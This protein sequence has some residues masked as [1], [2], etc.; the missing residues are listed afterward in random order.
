MLRIIPNKIHITRPFRLP[1]IRPIYIDN[2]CVL[3]LLPEIG[4]KWLDC[5]RYSNNGA[6]IGAILKQGRCG[7][8]L[9]FDGVNDYIDCGNDVSLNPT[10][11]VTVETWIKLDAASEGKTS[12]IPI[13][14]RN[15]AY[16]LRRDGVVNGGYFSFFIYD[17]TSWELGV[18][19]GFS[20]AFG[21]WYHIIGT[22]D[23]QHVKIYVNGRLKGSSVRTGAMPLNGNNT[24]IGFWNTDYFPGLIDEVRIYNRALLAEE[25]K[26]LYF[27]G[28]PN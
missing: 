24:V 5:S 18:N 14:R 9:W 3:C 22:Y 17:G 27:A 11:A 4:S 28:K 15:D 12:S 10:D 23:G 6:I 19:S 7:A 1:H 2:S 26:N 8:A 13:I 25:I 21:V 16:L 20:P